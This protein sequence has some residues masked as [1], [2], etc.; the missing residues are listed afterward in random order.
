MTHFSQQLISWQKQHGRHGLPWQGTRDAYRIWLSEIMLQ[1]TQVATVIPYYARFLARFPT[2]AELASASEDE[3]LRLWSGLGYYSRGRNL[4]RAALIVAEKFNGEFPRNFADILA[5]PG[6]GRSTAAAISAFAFGERRAILDGNVK[7]VF[8]RHFGVAGFP[9]D[10]RV[11]TKLWEQ[12]E[13]ALPKTNIETYTQAL[14]DLGATLCLR[15]RPLCAACPI[16]ATCVANRENRIHE[17]PSPRPKKI[18]PEKSTTMLLIGHNGEV[19]LE[20]RPPTGVWASLWCFPELANGISAENF[21]RER[22]GLEIETRRPWDVLQHGFTHFKLSITPRPVVVRSQD[23]HAGEPGVVW[24]S[25][26]DAL[27]AAIPKPVRALLLKM[28]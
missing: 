13:R 19:L 20:K 6:V 14:M 1:Q 17:L 24:L 10:K 18:V 7:R 16:S 21:C 5:L 12:A 3:V 22:F 26:E 2:L 25:V 11:E 27:G 28:K 9:G 4:L 8:A 15:S 23:T